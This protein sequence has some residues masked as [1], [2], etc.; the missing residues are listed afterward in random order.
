MGRF[1]SVR[2][3]FHGGQHGRI[4]VGSFQRFALLFDGQHRTVDLRQLLF[5]PFLAF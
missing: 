4:G 5:V 1:E 3:G 2:R